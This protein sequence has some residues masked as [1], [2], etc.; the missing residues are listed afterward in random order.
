MKGLAS[1]HRLLPTNYGVRMADDG[2]SLVRSCVQ[3]GRRVISNYRK[4]ICPR[5]KPAKKKLVDE[6]LTWNPPAK[7][8]DLKRRLAKKLSGSERF[9][10]VEVFERD[11]WRC[12]MCGANTPKVLRGTHH[13]SAPELDHIVTIFEGGEHSR[14]NTACSCRK[15]NIAK[16][17]KSYGQLRLLA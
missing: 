12:H 9:D 1:R 4:V 3:C 6:R 2:F 8:S 16:G 13:D 10:P 17:A 15:C 11:G 5:C 7:K 14:R